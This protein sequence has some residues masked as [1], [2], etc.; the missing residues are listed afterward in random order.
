MEGCVR[1]CIIRYFPL[2]RRYIRR[3]HLP[4]ITPRKN[5]RV[6]P[7]HVHSEGVCVCAFKLET[8]RN[9]SDSIVL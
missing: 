6:P 3:A 5:Q 9:L 7:L 1:G 8:D 4:R 2:D